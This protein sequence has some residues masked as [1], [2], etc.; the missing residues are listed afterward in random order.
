M[1]V[2]AHAEALEESGRGLVVARGDGDDA[3][4]ALLF[5]GE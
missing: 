4:E 2:E 3:V 5:D 1:R